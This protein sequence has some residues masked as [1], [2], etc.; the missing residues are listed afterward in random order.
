[1]KK[2]LYIDLDGVIADFDSAIELIHPGISALP[3]EER[4]RVIHEVCKGCSEFFQNLL[5]IEGAVEAVLTLFPQ[6][7]I[8]FLSTPMWDVPH[9]FSG[10]CIWLEKHFG[11]LARKRLILSHRKDLQIGDFLVDDRKKHGSDAFRG[12]FIHFGQP[13]FP[14]WKE[15][16]RYL[17]QQ[18]KV[19]IE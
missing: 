14:T 19:E 17:L 4:R 5:L 3:E 2:I 13:P 15:T 9:S 1:M 12:E 8:Y 6:Y 11:E 7:E 16:L 18:A 10:K